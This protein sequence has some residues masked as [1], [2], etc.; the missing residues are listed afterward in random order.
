MRKADR[1]FQ[2][3]NLIRVH[4]PI[5]AERL[6]ERM[7]VSVRSVYRYVDDVSVSGIP[8]YGTPGIG[9]ALDADFEMPPLTL[10]RLEVDALMLG[11]E[12]LACTADPAMAQAA[13]ML[14]SK[15]GATLTQHK[16][17]SADAKVRALGGMALK[18]RA[19]LADLRTASEQQRPVQIVYTSLHGLVSQRNIYPLGLFYWGG[20]WTVGSWC[21][22]KAAYRDFRVDCIE[23]VS[24]A[25]QP[26]ALP[27][28]IG[29]KAYMQFQ[30]KQWKA[31]TLTDSTLSVGM[32]DTVPSP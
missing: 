29:L 8:I 5:S 14:L 13:N 24:L 30:A 32:A 17:D 28:G 16:M 4:Q 25:Y 31:K 27:A 9:Y 12:M 23:S 7:G 11:M 26:A 1:L 15:V 19:H 6:A 21:C 10:N 2:L 22:S 3:V 20:K 18:T